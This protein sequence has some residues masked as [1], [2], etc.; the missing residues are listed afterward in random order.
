MTALVLPP[1][2]DA[3]FWDKIAAKYSRQ[4]VA[5]PNAFERKIAVTRALLCPT[6]RVLDIGCGTGSLVLRLAP[7]AAQVHGLDFSGA[8]VGIAREKALT[9]G[10]ANATFELGT[11][12]SGSSFEPASLDGVTAYSLLHLV[13]DRRAALE[14]IHRLLKPGG[15]FVSSTVCLGHSRI[16]YG[17]ILWVMRLLGLAPTVHVLSARTLL[18]EMHAAGFVDVQTPN[19]GAKH[20]IAF[21]VAR[22]ARK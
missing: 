17:S 2:P 11:L 20:E 4:P 14:Q 22:R 13:K 15:F 16:P 7:F 12:D 1:S 18:E 10:V 19:V 9:L 21:V 6:D 3:R 5:D 8:M